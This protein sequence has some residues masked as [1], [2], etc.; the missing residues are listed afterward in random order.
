MLVK[1][2]AAKQ[3]APQEIASRASRRRNYFVD[4]RFVAPDKRMAFAHHPAKE[5]HIF[6]RGVKFRAERGIH[7]VQ[8]AALEEHVAGAS[9]IPIHFVSGLMGGSIE[10]FALFHPR[11]RLAFKTRHHRSKDSVHS[12]PLASLHQIEEP[13]VNRKLVVIDKGDEVS[14]RLN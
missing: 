10:E 7:P 11:W 14:F 12:I 5:I 9:L 3:R 4:N 2:A 6:A 13:V 1:I 8:D